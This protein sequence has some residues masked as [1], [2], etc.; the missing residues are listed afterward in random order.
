MHVMMLKVDVDADPY[1]QPR[2]PP[3]PEPGPPTKVRPEVSPLG[4]YL[5]GNGPLGTVTTPLISILG[6]PLDTVVMCVR[7]DQAE[8][9]SC[10]I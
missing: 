6:L 4:Q 8:L 3:S 1:D 7:D 5:G 9:A 10:T 2:S